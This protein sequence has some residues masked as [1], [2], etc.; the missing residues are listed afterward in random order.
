MKFGGKE[1]MKEEKAESMG[2]KHK[3]GKAPAFG[4]AK[5]MGSKSK[6]AFSKMGKCK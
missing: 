3:M 2:G 6:G 5:G 1:T 4:K